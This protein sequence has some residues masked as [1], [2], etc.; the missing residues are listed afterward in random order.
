M[1]I[2]TSSAG[3]YELLDHRQDAPQLFLGRER[4]G[5]GTSGFTADVEDVG[6][7][8]HHAK[9]VLNGA[10]GIEPYASIRKRI[11]GDVQDAHH[12]RTLAQRKCRS[13]R[14]RHFVVGAYVKR[15]KAV[16]R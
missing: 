4:I 1:S 16:K 10:R 15:E 5:A 13:V 6:S 14:K 7:F 2:D 9:T 12:E 11:G 8:D 3:R